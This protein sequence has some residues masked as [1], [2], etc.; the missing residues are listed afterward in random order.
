M[1]NGYEINETGGGMNLMRRP[2]KDDRGYVHEL[3][4]HGRI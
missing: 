4:A 1:G 3:H 2:E